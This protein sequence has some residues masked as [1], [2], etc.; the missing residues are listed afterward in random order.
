MNTNEN[1]YLTLL[2][3]A[4]KDSR[5]RAYS[6]GQFNRALLFA[7]HEYFAKQYEK[8]ELTQNITDSLV[9][10]VRRASLVVSGGRVN[11]P[12]DY[13]HLVG[14]PTGAIGGANVVFDM[15]TELE[16][17]DRVIDQILFPT[18]SLP[19]VLENWA[20]STS[21]PILYLY[22]SSASISTLDIT[23]LKSPV[24]PFLDYYV[25]SSNVVH[26]LAEGETHTA[27]TGDT[28]PVGADP[29]V[30]NT[31]ISSTLEMEWRNQD[32]PAILYLLLQH[33]GIT[34]SDEMLA[35]Y[36]MA[37]ETENNIT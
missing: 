2:D 33:F 32:R 31:Y 27:A 15:V 37:K 19:L 21:S 4:R 3:I 8:F 23:Y 17:A 9:P 12:A 35:Q 11:L 7:T 29:S 1:L 22:P 10:F 6:I 20:S 16:Y 26:Y 5:G 34:V 24:I 25:D 14:E 18:D 30:G 36:G 13:Y 28:F